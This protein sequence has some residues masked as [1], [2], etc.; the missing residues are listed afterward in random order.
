METHSPNPFQNPLREKLVESLT[1]PIPE[2]TTRRIYGTVRFPGKIF[3]VAGIR[4]AGKTM[5][6]HQ[7]QRERWQRAGSGSSAALL[8]REIATALRR[9]AWELVLHPFSLEEALR[10]SNC[11]WLGGGGVVTHWTG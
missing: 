4:R 2:G 3:A 1:A 10:H 11:I 9:R 8:S 7:I 5:F 6:V